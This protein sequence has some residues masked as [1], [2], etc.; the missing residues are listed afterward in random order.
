[1]VDTCV[2]KIIYSQEGFWDQIRLYVGYTVQL[3]VMRIHRTKTGTACNTQEK[4]ARGRWGIL[5]KDEEGWFFRELWWCSG[6]LII[7]FAGLH[8]EGS[9]SWKQSHGAMLEEIPFI[10]FVPVLHISVDQE[11]LQNW[12]VAK[13][14]F[15][16]VTVKVAKVN[17][18][19][20]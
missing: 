10:N 19:V 8:F 14:S 12:C 20:S 11:S 16:L 1:M 3:K 7:W 18:D 9:L 17:S 13:T 5:N 4:T 15:L 2:C 6:L